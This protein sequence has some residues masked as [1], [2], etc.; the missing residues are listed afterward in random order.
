MASNKREKALFGYA[1][2]VDDSSGVIAVGAPD[3]KIMGLYREVPTYFPFD[4]GFLT[5]FPLPEE[6]M[7]DFME[8]GSLSSTFNGARGI[9][10]AIEDNQDIVLSNDKTFQEGGS[11]YLFKR[12][13]ESRDGFGNLITPVV[14]PFTETMQLQPSDMNARDHFGFSLGLDAYTLLVGSLGQDGMGLDAG[15]A[16][17]FDSHLIEVQFTEVEFVAAEGTDL[18]LPITIKRSDSSYPLTVFYSTSDL[19]AK[20]IDSTKFDECLSLGLKLRTSGCGDYEQ[21]SGEITFDVGITSTTFYVRIM[22]DPCFE[23]YSEYVQV[24]LSIPGTYAPF[25]EG[26]SARIRIDDDDFTE[27]T[28]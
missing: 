8:E 20:G 23:H 19:T 14:I 13:D 28:C 6:E 10:Q 9:W 22:N 12:E 2:K 15:A 16:Y 25:G 26:L 4:Q 17:L 7:V 18:S 27:T 5:S 21:S 24:H 3:A 11:I 1:V